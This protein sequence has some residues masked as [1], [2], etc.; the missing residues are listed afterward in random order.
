MGK[1]IRGPMKLLNIHILI[2]AC[3][4]VVGCQEKMYRKIIP[5]TR[6]QIKKNPYGA[7]TKLTTVSGKS[8]IG[9]ALA[10]S[11][12]TLFLLGEKNLIKIS[13]TD[14]Q[15]VTLILTRNAAGAY[16][17]T[18]IFLTIPAL[19]GAVIYRDY[20]G[21]FSTIGLVT[22]GS[23]GIATLIEFSRDAETLTYPGEISNITEL[24]SYCRF[25]G[26]LPRDLDI[27]SFAGH[28]TD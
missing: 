21:E 15:R 17:K 3:F 18:T 4:L 12:D 7:Y 14:I 9:E 25:P 19:L 2:L 5:S 28:L 10:L 6:T 1:Q 20:N 23:G 8:I 13:V 16:L 24:V 26:G 11:D 22:I 27:D